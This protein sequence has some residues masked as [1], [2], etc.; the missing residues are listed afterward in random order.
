MNFFLAENCL[1]AAGQFINILE[2]VYRDMV[3]MLRYLPWALLAGIPVALL[4][5]F[6]WRKTDNGKRK[7]IPLVSIALFSIY[8]AAMLIITFL[9]R[10]SGSRNGIDLQ[11]F[12]TW[13]RNNRNHAFVVENVLLFIPYGFLCCRS[14]PKTAG[15]FRCAAIGALTSIGIETLQL[16]TGRGYFQLDDILTNILGMII[17]YLLHR[18][19]KW[20]L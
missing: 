1:A 13:G 20:F 15:L 18:L 17:G 5:F 4:I 12:S 2:Y 6:L 14:F 11:L 8:A 3:S 19:L 9:S 16:V 10:E 7:K